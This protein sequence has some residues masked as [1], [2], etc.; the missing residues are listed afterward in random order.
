M[1]E[2]IQQNLQ[3]AQSRMKNQA[4]K[5]RQERTFQ[6]GDWVYVKLQPYVQRYVHRRTNQKL[7]YKYFG[8]YLI[9]QKIG[10]V[11]Y[12]LQLPAS[13]QIHP[14]L[15]VSQLKKALPPQVSLSDDTELNLLTLFHSLPPA[16]VLATR[17]QLVGRHA[18][19]AALVQRQSCLK[20]WATWEHSSSLPPAL[21]ASTSA[22]A[23]GHAGA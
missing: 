10:A 18:L 22:A 7:S 20:H 2:H 14:V 15:H 5:N 6:V 12:K 19:P 9:L 8:P 21:S 17:L 11:A 23:R 1:L 3:R 4:D 16:Q 13:S